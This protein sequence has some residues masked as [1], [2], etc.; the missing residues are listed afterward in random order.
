MAAQLTIHYD[1]VGDILHIDTLAPYAEQESEELDDEMIARL[2][3]TTGEVEN[4]EILFY[5]TRLMR[6]ESL[7]LPLSAQLR[8][9]I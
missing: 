9:A 1:K 7:V 6:G 2:N 3:P 4:I 8:L 5:S